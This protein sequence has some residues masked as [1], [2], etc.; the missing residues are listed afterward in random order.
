M[1]DRITSPVLILEDDGDDA[2]PWYQGIEFFL[3]PRRFGKESTSGTTTA[4]RMGLRKR[5]THKDLHGADAAVFRPRF[6]R[7]AGDGV[8]GEGESDTLIASRRKRKR[9]RSTARRAPMVN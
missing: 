5:P 2:V 8:D 1:V 4:K 9:T 6:E 3:S 7:S